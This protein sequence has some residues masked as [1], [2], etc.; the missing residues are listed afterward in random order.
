F[1]PAEVHLEAADAPGVAV[2]TVDPSRFEAK[3]I[4]AA[5]QDPVWQ[6]DFSAFDTPGRYRLVSGKERSVEFSIGAGVYR[7][8]L[9]AAQKH[10]YFQRTRTA[11]VAPYAEWEG[12]SY[13]RP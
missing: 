11:L 9:V 7:R 2:F 1:E 12:T 8:A 13:L 4:D 5:S 3:G 6:V 10:F